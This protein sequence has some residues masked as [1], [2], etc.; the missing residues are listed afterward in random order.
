MTAAGRILIFT[1]DGKGKT[2]AA[3]GMVLRAHGHAIPVSA[4][5]F[6]KSDTETGEFAALKAMTGVEI[7]VTGLGFVP[8]PTDP[9]FADHRRAAEEGLRIAGEA[10]SSGRYGMVV[11]DE[12]CTAVALNLL[13]EDAV[14]ALLREA[15]PDCTVVLTGRGATEGLIQAADTVSEVRCIKH[16][17]DSGRKAQ[18]G[19]EF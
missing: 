12:I 3:L 5:Q 1:G 10:A 13:A 6:V 7:Y 11:L 19:V 15:A 17:F 9:R 2:T 4:I 16:G 18:K 14:L 8:R